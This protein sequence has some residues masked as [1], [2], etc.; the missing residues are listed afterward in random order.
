MGLLKAA[1][2]TGRPIKSGRAIHAEPGNIVYGVSSS[3]PLPRVSTSTPI[4]PSPPF[5]ARFFASACIRA[6]TRAARSVP[7]GPTRLAFL[8]IS[9][10]FSWQFLFQTAD[11]I[12]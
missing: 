10:R 4:A 1:Q 3:R 9:F 2:R 8:P 7:L 12:F 11:Y 5:L 6:A